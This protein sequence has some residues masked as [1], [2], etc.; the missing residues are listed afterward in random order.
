MFGISTD[1]F[2]KD[3]REF[4]SNITKQAME[5]RKEDEDPVSHKYTEIPFSSRC[6]YMLPV[7]GS[8]MESH[9]FT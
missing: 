5:M 1:I 9:Y 7:Q 6:Y 8:V 3:I 2:P 4:F